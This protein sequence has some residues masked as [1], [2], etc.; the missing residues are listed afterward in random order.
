MIAHSYARFSDPR[1][2]G[3]DSLRRQREAA[4]KFCEVKGWKL[5]SLTFADRGRS[6]FKGNKQ[7]ALNAF[8]RAVEDGRVQPGETL[9]VEA[10]DRLSRKGV[11]ATQ[12][13]VNKILDAGVNIA[14]LVPV[15]KVY[16]ADDRNDI[17][18]A[19]EL[20][21]FAYQASVYSQNLSSRIK[22]YF[23]NQRRQC[24]DGNE[25]R[26]SS[27]APAWLNWNADK[28]CFEKKPEAIKA[29]KYIFKRTIAGVGRKVLLKEL[30]ERFP[31]ISSRK[32]TRCWN[33]TMIANI[34]KQRRVLGEITSTA[35]GE[36]F[37]NYYPKVIDEATWIA[38][39]AA[40]NRRRSRRGAPV[41]KVNLFNGLL[42]HAFDN[43]T[44]GFFSYQQKR[45]DGRVVKYTRYKSYLAD[46][47][48]DGASTAT[49]DVTKFEDLVFAFLPQ[50][51]LKKVRANP[52][53]KLEAQRE[54]IKSEISELQDQI[55]SG[56]SSGAAVLAVP[57]ASLGDQLAVIESKLQ[58]LRKTSV[59]PTKVYRTKL[60]KM[61]RGT[62]EERWQVRERIFDIV[63]RIWVLPI[64][65][66]PKRSDPVRSLVEIHFR[67]GEFVRALELDKQNLVKISGDS[68]RTS[69]S[70]QCASGWTFSPRDY[71]LA[72]ELARSV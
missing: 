26:I 49:I 17:G 23:E 24:K 63:E 34:V 3:G 33:E 61:R 52:R 6:G 38:A 71:S 27:V 22:S 45:A 70:E 1:Q 7:K 28:D 42:Y 12:N 59:L 18:G 10:V 35:S 46:Q 41:E 39:N 68:V 43:C 30:N 9:L 25:K 56:S 47:G 60:A 16:W 65:L 21:A 15:E 55:S 29:I 32:N 40:V 69:L 19:I 48:V 50:I 5:S 57:L 58:S 36:V 54:F 64:K 62:V 31:P 2:E 37:E 53:T 72:I 11:R 66:G 8:L 51:D 4:Q 14:I 13:L 44:M 67:N 20:A